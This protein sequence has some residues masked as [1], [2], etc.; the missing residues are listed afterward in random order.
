MNPT[1]SVM[2]LG[3]T[4]TLGTQAAVEYVCHEDSLAQLLNRLKIPTNGEVKPF[5]VVL[6]VRVAR[7][8]PVGSEIVALRTDDT[9]QQGD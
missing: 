2:M 7:G 9:K 4:S 8:V 1:E 5:E 6:R 3:G